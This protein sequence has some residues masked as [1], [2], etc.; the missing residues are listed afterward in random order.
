[1][2]YSF[3]ASRVLAAV[4][5][6]RHVAQPPKLLQLRPGKGTADF[7]ERNQ[8]TGRARSAAFQVLTHFLPNSTEAAAVLDMRNML[9]LDSESLNSILT[10]GSGDGAPPRRS[11]LDMGAGAGTTTAQL[12]RIFDHVTATEVSPGCLR[13][14]RRLKE[15]SLSRVLHAK[16]LTIPE[17]VR[18]GSSRTIGD[19][20]QTFDLVCMFNLLDRCGPRPLS[21]LNQARRL[22]RVPNQRESVK[23]SVASSGSSGGKLLVALAYPFDPFEVAGPGAASSAQTEKQSVNRE[24]LEMR[25]QLSCALDFEDFVG[26]AVSLFAQQ[27]LRCDVVT[28]APYLCQADAHWADSP[29]AKEA[30][31]LLLCSEDDADKLNDNVNAQIIQVSPSLSKAEE[32]RVLADLQTKF[33]LLDDALFLLTPSDGGASIRRE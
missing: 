12:Q 2:P 30:R 13:R 5:R 26:R 4:H 11:C 27:G 33:Y 9:V 6:S 18:D 25:Q 8:P 21:L 19:D 17:E 14:L 28:R 31:E 7:I 29:D 23:G 22:V 3:N 32:R 20:E 16:D 10:V 1:M 15:P 24:L